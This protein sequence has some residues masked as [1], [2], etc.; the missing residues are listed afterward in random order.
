MA[1]QGSE[2][3]QTWWNDTIERQV[4]TANPESLEELGDDHYPEDLYVCSHYVSKLCC[5]TMRQHAQPGEPHVQYVKTR[6]PVS[7]CTLGDNCNFPKDPDDENMP[8][9]RAC[10]IDRASNQFLLRH[11]PSIHGPHKKLVP[12]SQCLAC[13]KIYKASNDKRKKKNDDDDDKSSGARENSQ[14]KR[15]AQDD[16]ERTSSPQLQSV[17]A[18]VSSQ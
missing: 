18:I 9:Q 5:T 7:V 10:Y 14:K 16:S 4:Y 12:S 1:S 13:I 6:S 15:A 2:Q 17:V 11:V 3:G 8:L